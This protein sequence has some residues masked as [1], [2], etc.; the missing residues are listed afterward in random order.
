LRLVQGLEEKSRELEQNP[1]DLEPPQ[2]ALGKMAMQNALAAARRSL[3]ALEDAIHS[4]EAEE[5]HD[6]QDQPA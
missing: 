5:G 1:P 3:L 4:A 6:Q 2:I